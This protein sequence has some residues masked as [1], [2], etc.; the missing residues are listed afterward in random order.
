[1]AQTIWQL[2]HQ[3]M[4][5]HYLLLSIGPG[6]VFIK[7]KVHVTGWRVAFVPQICLVLPFLAV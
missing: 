7:T 6:P 5:L 1:M 4:H 3:Q 2:Q